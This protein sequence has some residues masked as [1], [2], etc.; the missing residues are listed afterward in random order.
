MVRTGAFVL[1]NEEQTETPSPRNPWRPGLQKDRLAALQL[2]LFALPRVS[3]VSG[4]NPSLTLV[5]RM[6]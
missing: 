3:L 1:Y 2:V 4:V 5:N 6:R